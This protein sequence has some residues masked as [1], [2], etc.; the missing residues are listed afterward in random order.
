MSKRALDDVLWMLRAADL[1]QRVN[2]GV[3]V[4]GLESNVKVDRGVGGRIAQAFPVLRDGVPG[5]FD[6]HIVPTC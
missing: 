4:A 6:A 1:V 5:V 2:Q 3:L